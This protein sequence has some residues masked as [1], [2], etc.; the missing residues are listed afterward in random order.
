MTNIEYTIGVMGAS[1][2]YR[3]HSFAAITNRHFMHDTA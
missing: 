2:S 1:P 3:L